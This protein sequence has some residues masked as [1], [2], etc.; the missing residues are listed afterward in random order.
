MRKLQPGSVLSLLAA[1][2]LFGSSPAAQAA[3]WSRTY[4]G[5]GGDDLWTVRELADG[6]LRIGGAAD[7]SFGLTGAWL[8]QLDADGT[9]LRERIHMRDETSFP[10]PTDAIAFSS[11]GGAFLAGRDV[12]EFFME[13][14]GWI[15]RVDPAG[16]IVWTTLIFTPPLGDSMGRWI[17]RD[18][19][20]TADGGVAVAGTWSQIDAPP[21]F[22]WIVKLDAAGAIEW[23]HLYG[24]GPLDV[25]AL[26]QT[27]EG[28]WVLAGA[29]SAGG[30][31]GDAWIMKLDAAGD[32]E[33]QHTFGGADQD[34]ATGIVELADGGYGVSGWTNS[35]T[36][37]SHAAWAL[38]LDAAGDLVWH[39][40]LGD[41]AWSDFRQVREAPGGGLVLLGRIGE[42]GFPSNDLWLVRFEDDATLT[43]QR[44]YEGPLGD[45]GASFTASSSGDWILAGTW[46][47]GF[48]EEDY[49]VLRVGPDGRI[50]GCSLMR[51][52][53]VTASAS[54]LSETTDPLTASV[55]VNDTSTVVFLSSDTASSSELQCEDAG[56]PALVCDELAADPQS[57]C[58]G[59]EITFT[60]NHTGGLAPV[61]V[62]WDF[63]GDT[64]TDATG[65][66]VVRTL[67]A[68][69]WTVTATATD[70]CTSPAPQSCS[71][72][73]M[74]EVVAST[75]PSEVSRVQ[76]ARPPL[77][78]RKLADRV[79][80]EALPEA[81]AY[82]LYADALGSWYEP[83]PGSG[84]MCTLTG[85]IDNGDGTNTLEVAVPAGHWIVVTASSA[86]AE[87]PAGEDSS[88]TE[89]TGV[90]FWQLCGPAP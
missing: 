36:T 75:P 48:A 18:A 85:W 29:S 46:G 66:P 11:D 19:V 68:G 47:W 32:F 21:I 89:R 5:S 53:S 44:A 34:A 81:A 28:G 61:T 22:A 90:G 6:T 35:F 88:G 77:R 42:P 80:V 49:W 26:H 55:P 33:W 17:S 65:N 40:V 56:C 3:T 63:D 13:H 38:R 59:E 87:G 8:L 12:R 39:R 24:G 45:Y 79:V 7:G 86:C 37:S 84:S 2:L 60:L 74:V 67:G 76:N 57:V 64:V 62:G 23:Q 14:D 31:L 16:D 1:L 52:T 20:A 41:A 58:E 70:T 83:S 10:I 82:N 54:R 50:P 78:V 51:D 73:Q 4:G 9:V 71:L 25:E 43:W 30:G 69:S 27:E 72:Q 15:A